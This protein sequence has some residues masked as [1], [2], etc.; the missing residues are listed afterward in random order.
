MDKETDKIDISVW[1]AKD[2]VDHFISLANKYGWGLLTFM[3]NTGAGPKNIFRWV[4]KILLEG[5][6][7][8]GHEYFGFYA[9]EM[10]VLILL[11]D[12]WQ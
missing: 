5:F 7:N 4:E 2:I 6:K 1:N 9:L 8:Q 3:V 11:Q 10:F 12:H